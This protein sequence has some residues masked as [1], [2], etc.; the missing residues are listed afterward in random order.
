MTI[1]PVTDHQHSTLAIHAIS[2]LGRAGADI[3]DSPCECA[4]PSH[5]PGRSKQCTEPPKHMAR[6]RHAAC[7]RDITAALCQDCLDELLRWARICVASGPCPDCGW[8]ATKLS[9][10][11]GPVIPL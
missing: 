5:H 4:R 9:D 2:P 6:I 3:I 10:I 1:T 7:G 8:C 11:V